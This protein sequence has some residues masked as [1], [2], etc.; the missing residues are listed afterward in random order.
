MARKRGDIVRVPA[1]L[2]VRMKR[3]LWVAVERIGSPMAQAERK[4]QARPQ[5]HLQMVVRNPQVRH[6]C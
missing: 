4:Q 6:A 2:T 1:S 5:M 3:L